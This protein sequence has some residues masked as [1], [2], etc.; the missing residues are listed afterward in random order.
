LRSP[1][2]RPLVDLWH[3]RHLTALE[4]GEA[5]PRGEAML[6]DAAAQFAALRMPLHEGVARRWLAG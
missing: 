4:G 2:L 5:R 3:G 6:R 1:L